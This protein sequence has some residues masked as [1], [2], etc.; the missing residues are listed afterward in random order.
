[1]A[2][3]CWLRVREAWLAAV[4][5]TVCVVGSS[6]C[7]EHTAAQASRADAHTQADVEAP[8]PSAPVVA[9]PESESDGLIRRELRA[10]IDSDPAL[11]D[12]A[13][14]FAIDNGDITVT[15][16]VRTESERQK[17]NELVMQ[18]TGVKSVANALRVS[19]G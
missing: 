12:R 14:T 10:A 6:G 11:K 4:M 15:G 17:I 1:M 18:V 19:P 2:L 8:G 5:F 9:K 3:P 7:R 16:S 13:I